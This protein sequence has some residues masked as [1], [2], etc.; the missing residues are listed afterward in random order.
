M[1]HYVYSTRGGYLYLV[2]KYNQ[3]PKVEGNTEFVLS[4]PEKTSQAQI[5][6]LAHRRF[7]EHLRR[8]RKVQHDRHK[9]EQ[10]VTVTER[11]LAT[12]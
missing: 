6:T 2:G 5:D 9:T 12:V 4:V 3:Q 1:I 10:K 7:M 8:P 11:E